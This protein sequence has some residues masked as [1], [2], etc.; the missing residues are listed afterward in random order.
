MKETTPLKLPHSPTHGETFEVTIESLS[1][2][3]RGQASVPAVVGPQEEPKDYTFE[4]RKTVP[5]DR[6]IAE[7]ESRKKRTVTARISEMLEASKMRT[8]PRCRHFGRRELPGEGCGGCA[9]Q[10]MSYRHQLA[11]K[12]RTI[13]KLMQARGVDPGLVMPIIGQDEPWY[14]RNKM[15]FSFGDTAER[16][17]A[18]G[19]YPKGYRYEIVKLDECFLQ[20]EFVSELLPRVRKWAKA[21]GLEPYQH[22]SGFLRTLTVREGKRTGQRMVELTTTHDEQALMDGEQV[23]A[24]EIADAFCEFVLEASRDLGAELTSVYWT[25]QRAQRGEPTRFF[26]HNIFGEPLLVE[27]MHLPD[28]QVLSFE[29]HPRAFFQPNTLQ[30]EVLYAQVL[31]KTGLLEKSDK[32]DTGKT[33]SRVLDLYCGTGTIGLCMARYAAKVVGIEMQPDAVENARQNARLN[34]IDNISFFTGDVA[35]VLDEDDFRSEAGQ[36]DLVVVDPPRAG[37]HAQARE[38]LEAIDAP[39]LV[40]V[41]C[42][43][44]AL[45][46]DLAELVDF[47]Y[48]IEV[49]QPVDMFPHTYHVENVALLVK[50]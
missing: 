48:A 10:S 8:E 35:K 23:P 29:I 22:N 3:G 25:Q 11:N 44:K 50:S 9:L 49:V 42:S 19:L 20:S 24:S 34:G 14:Y 31:E 33:G 40:Y 21:R 12:E 43:P 2:E 5:G 39:R 13:K 1:L 16:E 17:F 28:D 26:E 38:H 4:V 37:L 47:G 15:E 45:A 36:V 7:V 6:V 32:P 46:R 27:E 41:S 30:A 18:L